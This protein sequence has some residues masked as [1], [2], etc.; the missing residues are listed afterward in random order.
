MTS[1]WLPASFFCALLFFTS[2]ALAKVEKFLITGS[3]TVAP[4]LTELAKAFEQKEKSARFEV[5]MGGSSKGISDCRD[6]LNDIGMVSRALTVE[7]RDLQ[8]TT[9]ATDGLA[10]IVHSSNNVTNLTS[11]QIREI[12]TGQITNW[13]QVGGED[14][15][16]A[17]VSKA[18]GRAALEFFLSHFK[19]KNSEVKAAVIIGDEEQGVKTVTSTTGAIAFISVSSVAPSIK[20]KVPIRGLMVDGVKGDLAHIRSGKYKL[21]R[22]LNLVTR[23]SMKNE[24]VKRF[25]AF[26]ASKEGQQLVEKLSYIPAQ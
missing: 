16:I 3:S 10:F 11:E 19:L 6:Q 14:Q 25:L 7:E 17:V 22:P 24:T 12:Y 8:P 18:E 23:P 4:L 21:V 26:V 2:A 5:Q 1:H 15:K 9:I 20:N 13:K